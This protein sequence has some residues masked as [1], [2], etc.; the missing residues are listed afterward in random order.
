MSWAGGE[1]LPPFIVVLLQQRSRLLGEPRPF[2]L[3]QV[4]REAAFVLLLPSLERGVCSHFWSFEFPSLL[5][6]HF[7]TSEQ[8][9]SLRFARSCCID[10]MQ[11]IAFTLCLMPS[12]SH[13]QFSNRFIIW[14]Q[15]TSAEHT[16]RM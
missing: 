9:T 12:S 14:K 7:S 3:R 5:L 4:W 13:L 8:K 10:L 6:L 11:G 2:C 1:I 15:I 16:V